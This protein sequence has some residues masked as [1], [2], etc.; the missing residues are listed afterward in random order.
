MLWLSLLAEL[1][2]MI[3][4]EEINQFDEVNIEIIKNILKREEV[5]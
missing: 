1:E 4:K 2:E 5:K 3:D